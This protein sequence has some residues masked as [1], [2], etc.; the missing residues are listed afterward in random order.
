[1]SAMETGGHRLRSALDK[2]PD[3]AAASAERDDL[4]LALWST[5]TTRSIAWVTPK[6]SAARVKVT[7]DDADVELI[8]AWEWLADNECAAR[9]MDGAAL[10]RALRGVATGSYHG[11]ARAAM[12]DAMG[13]ITR[14]PGGTW[15]DFGDDTALDR[16][17]S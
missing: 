6:G 4:W 14:V 2:V 16:L 7:S 17:A 3:L 1:M 10:Y 8:A 5:I 13:G 12:A 9:R 11:S 15:I